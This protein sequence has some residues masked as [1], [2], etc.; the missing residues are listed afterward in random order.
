MKTFNSKKTNQNFLYK[1]ICLSVCLFVPL[2]PSVPPLPLY[3]IPRLEDGRMKERGG[4][5]IHVEAIISLAVRQLFLNYATDVDLSGLSRS[6][7]T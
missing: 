6:L 7:M 2:S 4:D 1:T 3:V 5:N